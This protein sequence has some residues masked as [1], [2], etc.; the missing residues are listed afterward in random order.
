MANIKAC[1]RKLDAWE[2]SPRRI[3][4]SLR[5][6]DDEAPPPEPGAIVFRLHGGDAHEEC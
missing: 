2:P 6:D 1:L 5:W 3:R 4:F